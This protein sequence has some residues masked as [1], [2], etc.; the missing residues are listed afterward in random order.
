MRGK[1]DPFGAVKEYISIIKE[2]IRLTVDIQGPIKSQVNIICEF[3]KTDSDGET[4]MNNPSLN[5]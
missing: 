3:K 5:S 4:V 2:H 1:K